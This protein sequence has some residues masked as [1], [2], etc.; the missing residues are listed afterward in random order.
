MTLWF[1]MYALQY[2]EM[3]ENVLFLMVRQCVYFWDGSAWMVA[4]SAS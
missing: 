1:A 3:L 2:K 4:G